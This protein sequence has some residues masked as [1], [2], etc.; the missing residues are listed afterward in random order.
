MKAWGK[1][2][3]AAFIGGSSNALTLVIV[4]PLDFNASPEGVKKLLIAALVSGVVAMAMYL[5]QS[6]V[7]KD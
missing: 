2:L 6:P 3:I 4:D 5:K 1:G 7:P